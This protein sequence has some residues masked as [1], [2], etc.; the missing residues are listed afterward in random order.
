MN[1]IPRIAICL[2]ALSFSAFKVAASD[3]E[4]MKMVCGKENYTIYWGATGYVVTKGDELLTS[5]HFMKK[6][7]GD[8]PDASLLTVEHWGRNGGMHYLKTFIFNSSSKG[9]TLLNQYLDADNS[10]R[11]EP[12]LTKCMGSVNVDVFFPED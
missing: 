1:K 8:D 10:P 6:T 5:P 9:I 7:Y 12:V 11:A 2:L 3:Y 4:P